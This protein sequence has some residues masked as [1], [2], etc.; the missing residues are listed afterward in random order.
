MNREQK[1]AV[2]ARYEQYCNCLISLAG[3]VKHIEDEHGLDLSETQDRMWMF[4][5]Q[6]IV[7]KPDWLR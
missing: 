2:V 1:E 3:Q 5:E 4:L 6:M 7:N